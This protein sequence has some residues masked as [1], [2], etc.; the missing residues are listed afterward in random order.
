M[1]LPFFAFA[2]LGHICQPTTATPVTASPPPRAD[3]TTTTSHGSGCPNGAGAV[4]GPTSQSDKLQTLTFYSQDFTL[5]GPNSA[6]VTIL[7]TSKTCNG[8]VSLTYPD[9]FSFKLEAVIY[10]VMSRLER[11]VNAYFMSVYSLSPGTGSGVALTAENASI[12]HKWQ[13]NGTG[14]AQRTFRRYTLPDMIRSTS[15]LAAGPGEG[16]APVL[17]SVCGR[18]GKNALELK[19]DTQVEV[20]N[21]SSVVLRTVDGTPDFELE[22]VQLHLRWEACK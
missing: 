5:Y 14:R 4:I 13:F 20:R 6:A 3:I 12:S 22:M 9:G 1:I 8:T 19:I 2:V 21:T 17:A 15:G 11:E 18:D 16:E 7:D 10:S